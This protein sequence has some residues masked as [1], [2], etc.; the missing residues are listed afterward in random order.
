MF[1]DNDNEWKFFKEESIICDMT[2]E[3]K[4]DYF[5]ELKVDKYIEKLN[6]LSDEEIIQLREKYRQNESTIESNFKKL[7]VHIGIGDVVA[8]WIILD[9]RE[10]LTHVIKRKSRYGEDYE[11]TFKKGTKGTIIDAFSYLIKKLGS[12]PTP[13]ECKEYFVSQGIEVEIKTL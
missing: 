13:E 4:S 11:I 2:D 7:Y 6:A 1:D 5:K 9:R 10:N 8:E 12:N 3:Q